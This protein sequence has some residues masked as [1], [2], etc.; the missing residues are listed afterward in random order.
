MVR[1]LLLALAVA[2]G[3]GCGQAVGNE[4]T[5]A[6]GNKPT[7]VKLD[8]LAEDGTIALGVRRDIVERTPP[9]WRSVAGGALEALL[10]GPT[11]ERRLPA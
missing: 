6:A 11:A 5:P 4:P 3:A 7:R 2:C 8:F 9:P 10:A 1:V